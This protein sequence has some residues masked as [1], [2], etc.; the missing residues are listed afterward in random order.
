MALGIVRICLASAAF[1]VCGA[2]SASFGSTG[3]ALPLPFAGMFAIL[4]LRRWRDLL[5]VM[6]VVAAAYVA[7]FACV[8]GVGLIVGVGLRIPWALRSF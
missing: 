8:A 4:F 7:G 6:T 1:F 2:V 5:A 3:Y